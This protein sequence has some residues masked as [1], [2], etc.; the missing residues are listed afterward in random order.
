MVQ[1]LLSSHPDVVIWGEH[2]GQLAPLLGAVRTLRAREAE[3]A[4]TPRA[5]YARLG[6]QAFMANLM[7]EAGEIDDAG[8]A[9]VEALFAAPAAAR[10]C[11]RWGFKETLY[12]REHGEAL[13]SLFPELRAVHVT[14]DPRDIL[15]SLDH[16]ERTGGWTRA[17]TER[18][19]GDWVAVNESFV[20]PPAWVSS[21]RYEDIV[22]EP[23][24]FARAV[25]A[26]AGLDHERLDREVF[27]VRVHGSGPD[28]RDARD[29]RGFDEL[30][31]GMRGLLD[32]DRLRRV[33]GAYGY[34]LAAVGGAVE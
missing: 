34:E 15:V 20:D 11:S 32:R 5:A 1:R 13:R 31:A 6:H 19:L 30:P 4:A 27:E 21:H 9:F 3:A 8:R 23:E 33:A 24:G 16:W 26:F 18:A 29:L 12:R 14:R 25:A 7:P 2:E 28:G 22:A 17:A 10:G